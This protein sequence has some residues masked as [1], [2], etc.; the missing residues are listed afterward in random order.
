MTGNTA[1]AATASEISEKFPP[2]LI[3]K[4]DGTSLYATRDLA[5]MTYRIKNWH[6]EKILYVVDSAQS[7][8]F[9]QVFKILELMGY[10]WAARCLHVNLE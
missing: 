8:H 7:L 10:R 2:M 6:P 4:S 5:Q 1:A 9:Q 3:R